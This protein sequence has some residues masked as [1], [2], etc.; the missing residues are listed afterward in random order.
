MVAAAAM[1]TIRSGK[2]VFANVWNRRSG[3]TVKPSTRVRIF[4]EQM[5]AG[6]A[7]GR[8]AMNSL[9]TFSK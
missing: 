1:I 5:T 6:V 8:L 3:G 2:G 9:P 7:L 4:V